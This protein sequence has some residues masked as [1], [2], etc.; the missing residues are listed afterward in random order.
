[1]AWEAVDRSTALSESKNGPR[2][3]EA[4]REKIRTFFVRYETKRAVLLPALHIVQ[5]SLGYVPLAAMKEV[6]E[7][8]EI[9]PSDVL[10]VVTFYN[11]FWEH[12][13][14]RKTILLCQSISCQLMGADALAARIKAKLGIGEHETTADGEYSFATE[15]CLAGCDH[16]PCLLINEKLHKRVR[17][18]DVER[19]LDD[20]HNDRLEIERSDLFDGVKA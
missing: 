14:G 3:S 7:L 10:D 1:M 16:A 5:D 19:L 8:L 4:V 15:E 17:A 18:E 20:E 13:R 12:K 11:H 6:A 9:A 2:L